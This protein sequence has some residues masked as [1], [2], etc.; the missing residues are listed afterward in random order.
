[1][2]RQKNDP[3]KALQSAAQALTFFCL[4][5]FLSASA[6]PEF[7]AL[8]DSVPVVFRG[9]FPRLAGLRANEANEIFPFIRFVLFCSLLPASPAWETRG[10]RASIQISIHHGRECP[11]HSRFKQSRPTASTRPEPRQPPHPLNR[12]LP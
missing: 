12:Q 10:S 2:W 1:M 9:H 6:A 3:A 8:R 4:W 11:P 7:R 5:I